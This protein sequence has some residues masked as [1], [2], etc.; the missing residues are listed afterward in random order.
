M[1]VPVLS[2]TMQVTYTI[3]DAALVFFISE[4]VNVVLKYEELISL[5]LSKYI[6]I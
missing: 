2:K 3:I 5:R 6:N 1:S 4:N